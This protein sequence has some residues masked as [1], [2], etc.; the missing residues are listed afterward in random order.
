[1]GLAEIDVR[2]SLISNRVCTCFDGRGSSVKGQPSDKGKMAIEF[3]FSSVVSNAGRLRILA[4]LAREQAQEF[5]R[6]RQ[7]TRLTEGN[8]FAHA[9]GLAEAGLVLIEKRFKE[10]KPVTTFSITQA[11]K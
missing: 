6:L 2:S 1:M 9:E 3:T 5:V 7:T 10:G 8:L 4:A 11:G